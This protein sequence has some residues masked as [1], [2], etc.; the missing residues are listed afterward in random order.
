MAHYLELAQL[1]N[2]APGVSQLRAVR[3]RWGF[4]HL[5]QHAFYHAL[6][7]EADAS[8]EDDEGGRAREKPFLGGHPALFEVSGP[9][10]QAGSGPDSDQAERRKQQPFGFVSHVRSRMKWDML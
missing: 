5:V 2:Q 7:K 3:R 4:A 9:L 10:Y 1:F 8:I 6:P